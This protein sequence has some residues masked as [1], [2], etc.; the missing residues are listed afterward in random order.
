VANPD[1]SFCNTISSKTIR[2]LSTLT[3]SSPRAEVAV[4]IAAVAEVEEVAADLEA[5]LTPAMLLPVA[6]VHSLVPWR[7]MFQPA[8]P[9]RTNG[10]LTPAARTIW[11]T[12]LNI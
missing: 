8:F 9:S 7:A 5:V 2:G 10:Y 3:V 4:T 1:M 12:T 11:S 6:T